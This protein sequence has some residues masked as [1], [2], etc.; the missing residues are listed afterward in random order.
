MTSIP[1]SF[2]AVVTGAGGGLGHA[3]CELLAD[4]PQA[5]IVVSDIDLDAANETAELIR[6]RGAQAI[7]IQTDVAN[8]NAIKE[9]E[10]EAADW[11][12]GVDCLI[13]NAG[14]AVR[15]DIE[16][17]SL[18]DWEWIMGI[19]VWGVLYGCRAFLPK[20]KQQNSGYII[21]VASAAGLMSPPRLAPYNMT[22]A[23]VVSLSETL[24]SE[25]AHSD[26]NV[27]VLCPTFF[28]TNIID[29][30]RGVDSPK[31]RKKINEAMAKSKVQAP[32]V[33][34][35]A[36][37]KV[38]NGE[39]YALPMENATWFWRLK[40]FAPSFFHRRIIPPKRRS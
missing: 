34:Q 9:L 11:M 23:A 36:L 20:M 24:Y 2:R 13:N 26:I 40:R 3:F 15:G 5:Q 6:I 30:G 25:L 10:Q 31:A 32:Q 7:A 17:I 27:T 35:F 4:Q 14:V 28:K 8:W 19:N 22:K 39:L 16:S 37:E 1:S 33:A 21:N 29:S 38:L 18:E 12:G